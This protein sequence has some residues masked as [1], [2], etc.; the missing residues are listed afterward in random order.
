MPALH[1]GA[2]PLLSPCAT[3]RSFVQVVTK[4][5]ENPDTKLVQKVHNIDMTPDGTY[6]TITLAK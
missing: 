4:Q 6:T 3:T 2:N 1:V 5:E